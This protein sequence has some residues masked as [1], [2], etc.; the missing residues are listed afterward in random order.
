MFFYEARYGKARYPTHARYRGKARSCKQAKIHL[1]PNKP[2]PPYNSSDSR[3]HAQFFGFSRIQ[4]VENC[5]FT[6]TQAINVISMS[7]NALYEGL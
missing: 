1:D 4:A 2:R 3:I 5:D 6:S 7:A